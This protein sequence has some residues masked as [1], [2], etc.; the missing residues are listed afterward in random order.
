MSS[1][2]EQ[3]KEV[4][5]AFFAASNQ[6]ENPYQQCT[7]D[8]CYTIMGHSRV[9]G[10]YVGE[11][12]LRR[13]REACSKRLRKVHLQLLEMVAEGDCV[14]AFC[15]GDCTVQ[16]GNPY[17]N[18]YVYLFQLRDGRISE[19]KFYCDSLLLESVIFGAKLQPPASTEAASG[20]VRRI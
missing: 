1:R 13:G 16:G 11:E 6:G 9:A 2:E 12:Q 10:T 5:R 19:C 7:E 8:F 4:I 17:N 3:N 20:T 15:K 18:D 14:V